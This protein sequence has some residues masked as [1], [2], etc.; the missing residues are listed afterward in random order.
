MHHW[1]L[2]CPV[3]DQSTSP[4]ERGGDL[5]K[6]LHC[7]TSRRALLAFTSFHLEDEIRQTRFPSNVHSR[8]DCSFGEHQ[9]APFYLTPWK[10]ARGATNG[11]CLCCSPP[12]SEAAKMRS[13]ISSR[14]IGVFSMTFFTRP[15]GAVTSIMTYRYQYASTWHD[16][17]PRVTPASTFHHPKHLDQT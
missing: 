6:D 11:E 4:T 15:R 2:R 16:L 12:V 5:F 10:S 17:E 7:M 3:S 9:A 13:P 8:S 1:Q 14:V